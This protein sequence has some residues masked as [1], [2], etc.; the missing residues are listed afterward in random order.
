MQPPT[1]KRYCIQLLADANW[2]QAI[3]IVTMRQKLSIIVTFVATTAAAQIPST[4][5]YQ[6]QLLSGGNP[7]PDDTYTLT[8]S[9]YDAVDAVTHVWTEDQGVVTENG[10][11]SIALGSEEPFPEGLFDVPLW[12]GVAVDGESEMQPRNP[13]LSVPYA[14]KSPSSAGY[15]IVRL[16]LPILGPW[17]PYLN[18]S[19]LFVDCPDGMYAI[20]GGVVM[21]PDGASPEVLNDCKGGVSTDGS[22]WLEHTTCRY[23]E[24]LYDDG[25]E[26]F[27][28]FA[29]CVAG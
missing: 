7:V 13:L 18:G 23:I 22:Q 11:Y 12:L 27:E 3:S 25:Y 28:L 6:S 17:W 10:V 5:A 21:P 14:M 1:S 9:M 24:D 8:F 4:I 26:T 15:E 16:E 20:N 19:F 29:I 2:R